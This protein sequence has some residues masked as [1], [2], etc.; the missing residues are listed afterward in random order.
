MGGIPWA[1]GAHPDLCNPR[2][3]KG[4]PEHEA[5]LQNPALPPWHGRGRSVT[6]PVPLSTSQGPGDFSCPRGA[7]QT[8][9]LQPYAAPDPSA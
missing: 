3:Q 8:T 2:M 1:S 9:R 4:V 7:G 6:L 5:A